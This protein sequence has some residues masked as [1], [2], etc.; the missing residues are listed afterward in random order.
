MPKKSNSSNVDTLQCP[1]CGRGGFRTPGALT[2][3]KL[4]SRAC[5][6]AMYS[7]SGIESGYTTAP[8]YLPVAPIVNPT[9][10]RNSG[11]NVEDNAHQE[12]DSDPQDDDL[13]PI[14][15]DD[16]RRTVRFQDLGDDEEEEEAKAEEDDDEDAYATCLEDHGENPT[17]SPRHSNNN[18][19]DDEEK[20]TDSSSDDEEEDE[21]QAE[22]QVQD[23]EEQEEEQDEDASV[24]STYAEVRHCALKDFKEY[25]QRSKSFLPLTQQQRDAINL[26]ARLRKTKASLATYDD[27][28]E[29]H[30]LSSGQM[31]E[32]EKLALNPYFISRNKLFKFLRRRYNMDDGYIDVE[33]IVL[34]STKTRAKIVVNY[35]PKCVQSLLVEPLIKD[36]DYLFNDPNDPFAPP[37][38]HLDYISDLNT[39]D[40]YRK[41]YEKLITKPGK[42]ILCPLLLYSDAAATGQ[43]A[44]LPIT[45]V[46]LSLGIFT[47]KARDHPHMWRTIGYIPKTIK[48][49]SR[50]KRLLIDS[51]HVESSLHYQ[52]LLRD[53]GARN[54]GDNAVVA[55]DF[56]SMLDVILESLVHMQ[57]AG[58]VWDL[59][60]KNKVHK[61]VEFVFY[62][63]FVRCDT[64]E[65]DKLCGKYLSR[66]RNVAQLCRYCHC[67]TNES[68]DPMADYPL[69]TKD[70]VQRLIEKMDLD[71]LKAISQHCIKNACYKLR[72]GLHNKMHVHGSCPMDMLHMMLLGIFKYV[73]DCFFEQL[74]SKT[75]KV[76]LEIDAL[77]REFGE[78]LH[79]QSYRGLGKTK[80]HSGIRQGKLM[81]KEFTGVLLCMYCVL[82]SSKGQKIMKK[83]KAFKKDEYIWD[84]IMLLETLITWEE[85]MKSDKMSRHEVKRAKKKFRYIMYLVKKIGRRAKG[86]GL[87]ITKFHAIMHLAQDILNFGIPMEV[88]TGSSEAGHKGAKTAAKLT[89][90]KFETF[91]KQTAIRLE[92]VH[93]LELAQHEINDNPIWDYHRRR[94][95]LLLL[96]DQC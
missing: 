37:P 80:F 93:L 65:A 40:S 53:E 28:M 52:Q 67:P 61:N 1:Y 22:D 32:G 29:W 81:A 27:I 3:H 60:Y 85:W 48:A 50:G 9:S 5:R 74:G 15:D 55:Q 63:A 78:L 76:A 19:S 72:F 35:T 95:N 54:N 89:Q 7:Q 94:L 24:D 71:A 68:D 18:E 41:T 33:N 13:P 79:R 21:V 92:E 6:D 88:D 11:P 34:P 82:R 17:L 20:A 25:V 57:D 16:N 83:C 42:Q 96:A 51:G 31:N 49:K 14:D 64:E 47:R 66:G 70:K 12:E 90:K 26:M 30:L 39:G 84:W 59:R 2:Q 77:A 46:K 10:N 62:V 58:M 4:M 38:A 75:S 43:F 91:D 44:H 45:A 69:K 73:R 8:E 86:M 23:D 36:S 56:H 87:K